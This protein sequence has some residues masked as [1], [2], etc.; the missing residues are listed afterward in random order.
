M[1]KQQAHEKL[2]RHT[3][4]ELLNRGCSDSY[5][6]DL[7]REIREDLDISIFTASEILSDILNQPGYSS[8]VN[9]R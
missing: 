4:T 2:F 5:V 1:T 3:M 9:I 6:E 7:V 8:G